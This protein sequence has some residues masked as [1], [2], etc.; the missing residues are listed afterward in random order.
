MRRP[1]PFG[2]PLTL[3]ACLD[4]QTYSDSVTIT[5]IPRYKLDNL[6]Q[7]KWNSM[8]T[9]LA[10]GDVTAAVV[11]FSNISKDLY[12]QRF[13]SRSVYL[14]QI[15]AGMGDIAMVN[16]KGDLA[17]YDLRDVINGVPCSFY[18]L[19]VKDKNGIWKI[20]NF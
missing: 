14:Y 10:A 7:G 16:V 20:R 2:L 5:V 4:G 17:E 9:A 12:Q 8:R 3:L 1:D 6:L 11:N 13:T 19:F 18:L 15:A